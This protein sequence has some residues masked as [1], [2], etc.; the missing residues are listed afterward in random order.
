VN[1]TLRCKFT[2]L[3]HHI[4]SGSEGLGADT[5]NLSA[6][7]AKNTQQFI[8]GNWI[9]YGFHHVATT[10]GWQTDLYCVRLDTD[11]EAR[12]VGK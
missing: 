10:A 7:T 3:G 6:L 11:A 12:K 8:A 4:W 1:L 9:V 5:I 2:I